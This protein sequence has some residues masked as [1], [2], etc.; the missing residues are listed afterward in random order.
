MSNCSRY[1]AINSETK[2]N[3]QINRTSHSLTLNTAA[4]PS[5]NLF[6]VS[7]GHRFCQ[8]GGKEEVADAS[9]PVG[10]ETHP[11]CPVWRQDPGW[12]G[13]CQICLYRHHLQRSTQGGHTVVYFVW[14]SVTGTITLTG[15]VQLMSRRGFSS[16][17]IR[18]KFRL[19]CCLEKTLCSG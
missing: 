5:S 16:I 3:K 19:I 6:S 9:H 1:P 12:H 14:M 18:Q 4:P 7:A 17:H 15:K 8:R 10:E 2:Q 11:W 13:H